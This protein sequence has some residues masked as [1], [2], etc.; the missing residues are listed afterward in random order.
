MYGIAEL[1]F[2]TIQAPSG[3]LDT[4]SRA[5]WFLSTYFFLKYTP[6][7]FALGSLKLQKNPAIYY[8]QRDSLILLITWIKPSHIN[9]H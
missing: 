7:F 2:D 1:F 6:F 9:F 5:E 8:L 3:K 4:P